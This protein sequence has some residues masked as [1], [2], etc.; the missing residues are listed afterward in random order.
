MVHMNENIFFRGE[1]L[2]L[3]MQAG[4]YKGRTVEG[5]LELPSDVQYPLEIANILAE[6]GGLYIR[7]SG[8]G[9]TLSRLSIK[10]EPAWADKESSED[11][12]LWDYST[13]IGKKLYPL[14]YIPDESLILCIDLA[15]KVYM[16]GDYLY[17][18]GQ[19]FTEGISNILL[20]IEGQQLDD[21][22][23]AWQ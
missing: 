14:G 15:G 6:F 12:I 4:W 18:V 13:R 3:L 7:S 1:V 21:Q 5:K 19:S 22:T 20:G 11:G 9:I 17:L 23:L 2:E 10:F 16:A 8:A